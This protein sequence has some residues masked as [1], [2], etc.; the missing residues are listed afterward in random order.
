MLCLGA[1]LAGVISH[2]PGSQARR[3]LGCAGFFGL[4]VVVRMLEVE[5]KIRVALRAISRGMGEYDAR[6]GLQVPLV[7]ATLILL[8]VLAFFTY[9]SWTARKASWSGRLVLLGQ[10]ATLGFLPLYALRI[11]SLHQVDRILYGGGFRL[12]WILDLG[13]TALAAGAAVLY[14]RH[15]R[16]SPRRK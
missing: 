9:R 11:I 8:M 7:G 13:L 2:R 4:L 10:I 1:G 5:E 3:W 15:C 14:I 6:S 16:R 12:N